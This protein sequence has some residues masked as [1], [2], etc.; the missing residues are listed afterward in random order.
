MNEDQASEIIKK[1]SSIEKILK[2]LKSSILFIC[3]GYIFFLVIK[4]IGWLA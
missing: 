4:K 2:E 3:C 1:L